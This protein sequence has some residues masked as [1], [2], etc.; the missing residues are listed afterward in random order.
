M[1]LACPA[2]GLPPV[3]LAFEEQSGFLV[4]VVEQAGFADAL[5]GAS[6]I[7][8][9]NAVA[10][11]YHL[12]GVDI[13]REQ[14]EVVLR[15]EPYDIADDG[16]VIWPSGTYR[17]EVVYALGDEHD[18]RPLRAV[19][20]GDP[21]PVFPSR[22]ARDAVLFSCHKIAW[23]DWVRAFGPE[24]PGDEPARCLTPGPSL[25]PA[26][27]LPDAPRALGE[28]PAVPGEEPLNPAAARA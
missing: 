22:L 18:S 7:V 26:R 3:A 16:L 13:V 15:G 24:V 4:A 23:L 11:L 12:A 28:S 8:F 21:L 17:T 19:V 10:G 20:R 2:L 25:L 5:D 14:L 1:R 27:H 9:E 6:R